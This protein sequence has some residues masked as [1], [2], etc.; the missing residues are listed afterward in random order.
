MEMIKKMEAMDV[1]SWR[2]T[3]VSLLPLW[4]ISLA[5]LP[6]GMSLMPVSIQLACVIFFLALATGAFLLV[7]GWVTAEVLLYSLCPLFLLFIF[8]EVSIAYK[9]PFIL[10]STLFLSAGIIGYQRS[11]HR[12]TVIVGWLILVLVFIG[13]LVLANHAAQNYWQMVSDLGIHDC[14]PDTP[15]C[16]SLAGKGLSWLL[17]F[18]HL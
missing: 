1:G 13:T 10:L 6:E 8:E 7:K 17:L 3:L 11:L 9:T 14:T 4:L 2:V 18:F 12:D 16:T 5:F 15:G